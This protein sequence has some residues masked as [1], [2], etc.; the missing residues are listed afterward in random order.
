MYVFKIT[1]DPHNWVKSE[2]VC[3]CT[4][5]EL[6]DLLRTLSANVS[7]QNNIHKIII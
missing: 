3:R 1:T 6:D 4:D 7:K 5:Q 2:K